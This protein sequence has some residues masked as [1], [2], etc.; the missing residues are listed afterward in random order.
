M[1]TM[2]S[3]CFQIYLSPVALQMQKQSPKSRPPSLSGKQKLVIWRWFFCVEDHLL[4]LRTLRIFGNVQ[5]LS[6]PTSEVHLV[7][8]SLVAILWRAP[9]SRLSSCSRR[10][11][12]ACR[13]PGCFWARAG[14]RLWCYTL[15][16]SLTCCVMKMMLPLE[17]MV[18]ARTTAKEMR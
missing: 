7:L 18:A 12:W 9:R 16:Y 14:K 11:C 1:K 13:S 3:L 8:T 4:I 17:M 15:L 6:N 10:R 5:V 2:L